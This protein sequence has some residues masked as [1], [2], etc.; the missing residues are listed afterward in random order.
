MD[1]FTKKYWQ[2]FLA[3]KIVT[4][5]FRFTFFQIF[6]VTVLFGVVGYLILLQNND[7]N[8]ANLLKL[9][10]NTGKFGTW[11]LLGYAGFQAFGYEIEKER[12]AEFEDK[13]YRA[14]AQVEFNTYTTIERSNNDNQALKH[15]ESV[16]NQKIR[17]KGDKI[18]SFKLFAIG[19]ASFFVISV[20][21][22]FFY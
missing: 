15:L 10:F 20:L 8:D 3:K 19:V 7:I 22:L 4:R 14:H 21:E 12:L 13:T 9:Y 16:D 6:S 11:F 1:I 2:T 5:S 17:I 18:T